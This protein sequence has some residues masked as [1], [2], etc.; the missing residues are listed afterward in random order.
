MPIK[1]SGKLPSKE[2]ES[3]RANPS[4]S[5][6]DLVD[7]LANSP[8]KDVSIKRASVKLRFGAVKL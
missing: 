5:G 1:S 4:V 8:L 3:D 6:K 2:K 7:A